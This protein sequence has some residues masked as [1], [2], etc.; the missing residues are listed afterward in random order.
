MEWDEAKRA[1]MMKP[2]ALVKIRKGFGKLRF[3]DSGPTIYEGDIGIVLEV[4]KQKIWDEE[5]I[6]RCM[7][8][9]SAQCRFEAYELQIISL[10]GKGYC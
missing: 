7:V 2:G 10:P 1:K 4:E 6:V 9:G 3:D 8:R 5:G